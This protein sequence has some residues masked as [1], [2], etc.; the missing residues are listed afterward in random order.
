MQ[1]YGRNFLDVNY[2]IKK[3][4]FYL[5]YLENDL[6][7]QNPAWHLPTPFLTSYELTMPLEHFSDFGW[8]TNPKCI[9]GRWIL[10]PFGDTVSQTNV[11]SFA[12]IHV[13][14][15]WFLGVQPPLTPPPPPYAYVPHTYCSA[16]KV[17]FKYKQW[18]HRVNSFQMLRFYRIVR[19]IISNKLK[20]FLSVLVKIPRTQRICI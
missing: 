9:S 2:E 10:V 8:S 14:S 18:R 11:L 19:H 15:A 20:A 3:I 5:Y 7:I 6:K 16:L 4:E 13:L 17:R 12:R 1:R